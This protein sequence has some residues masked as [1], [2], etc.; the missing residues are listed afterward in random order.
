VRSG[1]FTAHPTN[2]QS[3][4]QTKRPEKTACYYKEATM[5]VGKTQHELK[6]QTKKT[7]KT[8]RLKIK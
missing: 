1:H 7:I 8:I 3:E 2:L 6:S 5:I 4:S